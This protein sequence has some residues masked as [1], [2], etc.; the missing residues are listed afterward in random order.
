MVGCDCLI[1]SLVLLEELVNEFGDLEVKFKDNGV[2]KIL[3]DCLIESEFCWVMNEDVMVIE[4]LF[5]G[6]CNF[7]VD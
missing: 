4:K 5:E 3:G 1:I 2:I 7:V 6:I